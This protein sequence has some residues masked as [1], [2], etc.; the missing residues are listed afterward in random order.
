MTSTTT[1][2]PTGIR[3]NVSPACVR[4][5]PTRPELSLLDADDFMYMARLIPL[6]GGPVLHL[7]KHIDTRMYLNL[8]V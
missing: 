6:D 4:P 2:C 7:Y 1:R 3:S 8:D 5:D